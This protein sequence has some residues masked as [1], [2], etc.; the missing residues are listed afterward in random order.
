MK[1]SVIVATLL[2]AL[3]VV[4]VQGYT[5]PITIV[6]YRMFDNKTGDSFA[7]KGIDYY[8]RPNAGK[9]N[10]NNHDFFTD[11]HYDVWKDDIDYLA[12]TGANAVRLYAVDPSKSHDMFMC[13]LRAKGMYAL[14]DLAA[15]CT[16][17]SVTIEKY[18]TCYPAALRE[19]G[20]QIILAFAKYDNVLAFSAGNEV[21]NEVPE[22]AAINAPC[23][24]KF[25]R[26]M[27]NF[28]GECSS[29]R[30]IPV[31][32]VV[33]DPDTAKNNR[34]VNAKYYNCR[35]NNDKYEN[36]EW[37]GINAYQYCDHDQKTL[38]AAT[39]FNKL[40][41]DF[42]SYGMTI[43]VMLTE[44]GCL[45]VK[46]PKVGEYEAQ[47]TWLQAGWLFSSDFRKTFSGGF[48]FEYSTEIVN[49][50]AAFP[51]T[52]Y[53]AGNYGLGYFKPA[54]CNHDDIKCEYV[55]MP[56]YDNLAT[57]YKAVNVTSETKMSA[58]KSDRTVLPTCPTGFPK[59][60]DITWESDTVASKFSC[61][62]A[63]QSHTCEGQQSS[64]TWAT[65]SGSGTHSS[66]PSGSNSDSTSGSTSSS[67]SS[68]TTT[69][70]NE[71]NRQNSLVAVVSVTLLSAILHTLF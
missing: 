69:T 20:R 16:N 41:T 31:G 14:I 25:V 43:P 36:A 66:T 7:V 47:R 8:P 13:A 56:N 6:G 27:R 53:D 70:A 1:L 64:G 40:Q 4:D 15:S 10:E 51:F 44:Y 34:E 3:A 46:F 71:A 22:D 58:F 9:L 50:K 33:A 23:Q 21:N 54:N 19:R 12:S 45:N 68:A 11:A 17:C 18:P 52:S 29:I 48:A 67:G 2:T 30:K 62:T 63:V 26:D 32:L 55:P 49:V 35:G 5:N 61:P 38:A 60:S 37:Y 39:G 57:Q 24:K 28:I 65:G 59:L 42:A